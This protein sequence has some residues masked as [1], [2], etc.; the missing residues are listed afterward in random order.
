MKKVCLYLI[1]G[2]LGSLIHRTITSITKEK[3]D[4]WEEGGEEV[5]L[6]K[7]S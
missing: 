2:T 1:H 7:E 6:R 5:K 3:D 4:W